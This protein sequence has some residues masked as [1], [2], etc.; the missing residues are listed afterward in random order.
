ML[1]M[2]FYNIQP[3]SFDWEWKKSTDEGQTWQVLWKIR[4]DRQL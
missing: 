4:Y 3:N 1:K 2:V